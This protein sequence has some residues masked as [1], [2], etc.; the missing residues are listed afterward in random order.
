MTDSIAV[1]GMVKVVYTLYTL[2][3]M[4]LFAWFGYSLTAESRPKK[5]IRIPFY[6][7]IALLVLIGVS[8]HILTFNKIPWVEMDLKRAEVTPDRTVQIVIEDHKFILPGDKVTI[9]CNEKVLFSVDSKDLTY[10]FGLFRPDN[11]LVFQMQVVPGSKNDLLWQFG[12]NGTYT[13][14]STE[15]SGPDGVPPLKDAVEVQGCE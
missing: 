3:I 13:I 11:S 2:A 6:L 5:I 4:S 8:I 14:R 9:N 12:K 15:Y 1:L 10:G 7:Y